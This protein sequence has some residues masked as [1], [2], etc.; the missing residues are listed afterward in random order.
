MQNFLNAAKYT[1][2]LIFENS[3]Y[4][5]VTYKSVERINVLKMYRAAIS[6][7]VVEIG[8]G[9]RGGIKQFNIYVLIT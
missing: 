9:R 8:F 3:F 1:S 4:S 2:D 7:D 6:G 5:F